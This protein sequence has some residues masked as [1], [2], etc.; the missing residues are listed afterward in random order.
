M[1]LS[2]AM[3]LKLLS[4]GLTLSISLEGELKQVSEAI[5]QHCLPKP[6]WSVARNV[7]SM[8]SQQ[9]QEIERTNKET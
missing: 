3:S 9:E 6:L 8:I 1:V 5:F 7:V 2:R 4:R